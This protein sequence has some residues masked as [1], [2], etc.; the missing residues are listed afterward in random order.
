MYKGIFQTQFARVQRFSVALACLAAALAVLVT[1]SPG[2]Q[3]GFVNWDDPEYI[4]DNA[5]L[6][7]PPT[8][9]LG[10]ILTRPVAANYHPVTMVFLALLYG[11]GGTEPALFHGASVVLHTLNTALVLLLCRR[12]GA[13]LGPAFAAALLFGLHPLRVETVAWASQIKELLGSGLF[14]AALLAYG[15]SRDS[16]LSRWW[17]LTLFA[18]AALSKPT[19]LCFP[20]V[21]LLDDYRRDWPG[22]ARAIRG[23]IPYL[24]VAAVVAAITL[25]AQWS[26][27]AVR[28]A[29]VP[30]T[31]GVFNASYAVLFSLGK[32]LA[33][34]RLSAL[35]PHPPGD[36]PLPGGFLLAPL[37]LLAGTGIVGLLA[38]GRRDVQAGLLFF[39]VALLPVSQII[40]FGHAF[41]AD[42]YT[43][44][45][46][47]GLSLVVAALLSALA[48]RQTGWYR[49]VF[50]GIAAPLL[51]LSAAVSRERLH[52]W[53][54]SIA[55][56]D[57]TIAKNR[58]TSH[59]VVAYGNRGLARMDRGEW[60]RAIEDLGRAVALAPRD[61]RGYF[62][63][64]LAFRRSGDLGAA[65]EDYSRALSLTPDAADI[66]VNRGIVL[67][68]LG[69]ES[70][71]REDFDRA[72]SLQPRDS[73]ARFNRAVFRSEHGDAAG[74]LEDLEALLGFD[75]ANLRAHELRSRLRIGGRRIGSPDAGPGTPAHR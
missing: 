7:E 37:V 32:T 20:A 57:D 75:P 10:Q 58:D 49:S 46:A 28:T 73:N 50:V 35:Y 42:R 23:K 13:R 27:G 67:A 6:R 60:E 41:A 30:F 63:R 44:L 14:L 71:A 48:A 36:A 47:V 31:R 61:P 72:A 66:L 3:H 39:L 19:T 24:T 51:F 65:F 1:F 53:R 25:V 18:L 59:L 4:T 22:L 62:N 45:P 38:R 43:Y 33:P 5:M 56:W 17:S 52:V 55:L 9:G 2:L 69:R 40:P 29:D 74:A 26:A 70:E 68:G 12:W 11:L 54:D 64:G 8:K 15:A 16:R 34:F 21:L